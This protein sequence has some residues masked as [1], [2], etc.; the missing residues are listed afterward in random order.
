MDGDDPRSLTIV[1]DPATGRI[2]A[3]LRDWN[4]ALPAALGDTGGLDVLTTSGI[5]D[6]VRLGRL[7]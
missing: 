7:R 3:I 4:R 5:V 6:A 2:R 1:T